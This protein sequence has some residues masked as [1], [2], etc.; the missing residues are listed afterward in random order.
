MGEFSARRARPSGRQGVVGRDM[1][2]VSIVRARLIAQMGE[3][4]YELWFGSGS[5]CVCE[6]NT[7]TVVADSQFRLERLRKGLFA[8]IQV[9]ARELLG[10]E[11]EVA[12]EVRAADL[13]LKRTQADQRPADAD[14]RLLPA[15]RG[16]ETAR[17][18]EPPRETGTDRSVSSISA[19]RPR[20]PQTQAARPAPVAGDSA[21]T[22][23]HSLRVSRGR[24]FANLDSF[25]LGPCN[26]VAHRATQLVLQQPGQVN[27]L[28]IHGP[29]GV[30][31]T[32]LLEG[33]WSAAR[34]RGGR[35]IIYLS[36]EQFTTYFLQALRGSGLPSFRQKYREVDLLIL[37]D[38]QF[39]VGKQATISELLYTLD[40]LLREGRQIIL[41]ADRAPADL[42]ELGA[43]VQTRILGGL[44]C[45]IQ[46]L[47]LATRRQLLD[48]IVAQREVP[49][50]SP[51]LDRIAERTP[52]DARKLA[53]VINR[54]WAIHQTSGQPITM[55]QTDDV[56]DEFFPDGNSVVRLDDI[57]RVV[58]HEFGIDPQLLRSDRR[59]RNVSHPRMLAMWLA[60]KHTRA[61]LTEISEFF[62]RRSHSTVLAAQNQVDQWV[63]DG[64]EVGGSK[65]S[66]DVHAVLTRLERSLR[67]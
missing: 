41:S 6:G 16:E 36:A 10:P 3:D 57:Q 48:R 9:V 33:L 37:D 25:V 58:C 67:A 29:S 52:G 56:L 65:R 5:D 23:L 43:E 22:G 31:K 34:Q 55:R 35:R 40:A 59:S 32:H 27:P 63:Q 51:M 66:G 26:Q 1:E 42:R 64:R 4:R 38:I 47:D 53:G 18:T 8:D 20:V 44:V 39:F 46:P 14:H 12:F 7:L 30:G 17:A 13:E 49:L 28:L 62:G 50:T 2:I 54:L 11:A 24:S 19:E 61:A 15:A 21:R 45:D 60:R